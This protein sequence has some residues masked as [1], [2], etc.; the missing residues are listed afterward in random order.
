MGPGRFHPWAGFFVAGDARVKHVAAHLRKHVGVPY[1]LPASSFAQKKGFTYMRE[2]LPS[3][4]FGRP[5]VEVFDGG[6]KDVGIYLEPPRSYTN[7]AP[8]E[9]VRQAARFLAEALSALENW[10]HSRAT[11]PPSEVPIKEGVVSSRAFRRSKRQAD[12]VK[13]R[14]KYTCRICGLKPERRYGVDGRAC[15]EA[16]HVRALHTRVDDISKA[17]YLVTVCANCHRVLGR[18]PPSE[19]GFVQLRARFKP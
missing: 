9:L 19:R 12:Y 10:E 2:P 7:E 5:V 14:D 17:K 18:L 8:K 4:R 15:L 1:T 11:P 16:H 3:A 6:L 13:R